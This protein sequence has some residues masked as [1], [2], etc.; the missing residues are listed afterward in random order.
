[1]AKSADSLPNGKDVSKSPKKEESAATVALQGGPFQQS[2]A[3]SV[4][5]QLAKSTY[6]L[7]LCTFKMRN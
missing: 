1:M 2:F 6:K 3:P 7:L 4:Y 5:S